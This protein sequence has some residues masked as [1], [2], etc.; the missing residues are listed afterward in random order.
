VFREHEDNEESYIVKT[1]SGYI[2]NDYF[3]VNIIRISRALV[4]SVLIM[5]LIIVLEL[6]YNFNTEVRFIMYLSVLALVILFLLY[7]AANAIK[8]FRDYT[9]DGRRVISRIDSEY[10]DLKILLMYDLKQIKSRS[11]ISDAA[12]SDL[13][14]DFQRKNK[15]PEFFMNKAMYRAYSGLL[16][17]ALAVTVLYMNGPAGSAASRIMNY[18]RDYSVPASHTLKLLRPTVIAAERDSVD[19]IC[20]SKGVNPDVLT[21]RKRNI[22]DDAF[23]SK[24]IARN[25]DSLYIC[26]TAERSGYYYY[27]ESDETVSDTGFV[28]VLKSP[29]ISALVINVN[30]PRYT[31]IPQKEYSGIISKISVYKG[32][33]VGIVLTPTVPDLDSALILFTDGK[34]KYLTKLQ[35]GSY[36]A[37]ISVSKDAEFTFGLY[38][39]FEGLILKNI[40]P[41]VNRIEVI[42]DEYPIVNLIYPEDGYLID[43]SMQI[44]AFA[45]A[46]DDFEL[47]EARIFYRK[48]SF[49]EFSGKMNR[50]DYIEKKID[51][52]RDKEGISVVNAYFSCRELNLLP[53][54]KV[55]LFIR[56][57][58]NDTVSGPKYTDSKVRTV[59]LPS[60]E[61]LL[62]GT[63]ESY[64]NQD[65]VLKEELK[66]NAAVLEKLSDISEKLKKNQDLNWEDE[67]KF[68]QLAEEQEGMNK[69]L[70]ELKQDIEK[71]ISALD[72]NSIISDETMSKYMKLQKLVDELFTTEMKEKLKKLNELPE[73]NKFDKKQFSELLKDFEEQQKQFNEGIEKSI[74]ML[75]QIKNE[76]MLDRLIRQIDDMI[77]KQNEVNSAVSEKKYDKNEQTAKEKK[78][79][80]SYGFFQKELKN[81]S[82]QSKESK[83]DDILSD[84]EKK[85]LEKDFSSVS[86][87]INK[88]ENDPAAKKGSEISSKLLDTKGQ[89]SDL[90]KE[91]LDK[92]KEQ[93]KKE[94]DE[95]ISDLILISK[96]VENIKNFS[97]DI[98]TGSSHSSEVI[99]K[100]SRTESGFRK[101]S[102]KIFL[103]SKKTFFIDKTAIA[104]I[105][106]IIELFGQISIVMSNRY[107]SSTYDKSNYLMGGVNNLVV[108]LN[109]ARNEMDRSSSSS[110]LEEMLKKM[111]DMAKKQ[112][113]LNSQTSS[114]QN[115][116][117]Q[118][119]M[120]QMQEM[121]NRLAMEQAQLYDALMKMQGGMPK[122]GKDGSPGDQGS[123]KDGMQGNMPG[124]N[125]QPGNSGAPKS[126]S[127][128]TSGPGD[129]TNSGL[130]K[131]LGSI[132]DSMKEAEQQLKDKK[133]DESL[134][135][136]Q[137][138]VLDKLLDAIESVKRE[139]YENKR[140]SAS[141]SKQ[142]V[143]P[144]RK[145]IKY[146]QDLREM[147]IRSL[148]DGYTNKY[149]IKIK[150]YFRELEN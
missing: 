146:D 68:K 1:I 74:E 150:N 96:E 113:S 123:P 139:K 60:I 14:H 147:L 36:S 24:E 66:R 95:V 16:F 31:K 119:S 143:D 99:K 122:P 58:D 112:A 57:Y 120:S 48:L 100:F 43:E 21:L 26:R 102:D 81:L 50:T 46:T 70:E 13:T 35:N 105:G 127:Q 51:L 93:L 52:I 72:E 42:K 110:G 90:K 17:G 89:L 97:K 115:S 75:E 34:K 82:A 19:L 44:P 86:D 85:D 7:S 148:K 133:L 38:G 132:G 9:F 92:Q 141:G 77:T 78:I 84:L 32:S 45:T 30:S 54:D 149:K 15:K 5:L 83:F 55:E 80:S 131:R 103:I 37:E 29:D 61:Q 18:D 69:S 41:V 137:N 117:S 39:S 126:G 128:G 33:D 107:F 20:I 138:Q 22:N 145:E 109:D 121:M 53:E 62:A 101:V 25:N 65:K 59:M 118:M 129:T 73:M 104:Q 87:H 108:L 2:R 114:M 12:L 63:E 40:N 71:N 11:E 134:L 64:Q 144:G 140:E 136:K 111:E 4:Y 56:V 27:F 88:G 135:A 47:T 49:N 98:S 94:L 124:Q 23:V 3:S 28:N 106:R 116:S 130:G 6:S 8:Y 79:E 76:Y 67:K 142:A 10:T 125:G 91:M